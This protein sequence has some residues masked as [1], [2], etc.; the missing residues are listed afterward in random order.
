MIVLSVGLP[1]SGSALC[2]NLTNDLLCAAGHE[3]VR[4]LKEKHGLT[5]ILEF[6]NCN[7]SNLAEGHLAPL[8]PLQE[9]GE[10]FVVK[11]HCG[12]TP[13]A[14]DLVRA[15][16]WPGNV[17]QLEN[18]VRRLAIT[19]TPVMFCCRPWIMAQRRVAMASSPFSI[20]V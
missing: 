14:L 2:F 17:R 7:V 20:T 4:E 9:A 10:S 12:P 11:T 6:E 19:G 1:K 16:S 5:N 18:T 13:F 8:L 3:D 15:Y